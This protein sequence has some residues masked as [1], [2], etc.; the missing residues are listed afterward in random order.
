MCDLPWYRTSFQLTVAVL[1]VTQG[2]EAI[3]YMQSQ[4][5]HTVTSHGDVIISQTSLYYQSRTECSL[6]LV[7]PDSRQKVRLKFKDL[8]ITSDDSCKQ[9]FLEVRGAAKT[10][11]T[12]GGRGRVL[13]G[14]VAPRDDVT[15]SGAWLELEFKSDGAQHGRGFRVVFTAIYQGTSCTEPGMFKCANGDCISSRLRCD[16][17][18]H[19]GDGSDEAQT[20]YATCTDIYGGAA[21]STYELNLAKTVFST[22]GVLFT[23]LLLGVILWQSC[24]YIWQKCRQSKPPQREEVSLMENR[25]D[26]STLEVDTQIVD[27]DISNNDFFYSNDK[28]QISEACSREE[29]QTTEEHKIE[30]NTTN[31]TLGRFSVQK[32]H[33]SKANENTIEHDVKQK[34]RDNSQKSVSIEGGEATSGKAENEPRRVSIGRFNVQKIQDHTTSKNSNLQFPVTSFAITDP[35]KSI[36]RPKVGFVLNTGGK[37]LDR[38]MSKV[39][40]VLHNEDDTSSPNSSVAQTPSMRQG[41]ILKK[42]PK[43]PDL[44]S[45]KSK[46][47]LSFRSEPSSS[48][49]ELSSQW[50]D[51]T[52]DTDASND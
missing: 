7:A 29:E 10:H 19:C 6:K 23:G 21:I 8:D 15:S 12:H 31:M 11:A 48:D 51:T 17:V 39:K 38:R 26:D 24:A 43:Y 37:D 41:S 2:C 13:C 5:G 40:F 46:L 28:G 33:S 49:D 9:N 1:I 35:T 25:H 18:D 22:V 45:Y 50:S 47:T 30:N 16:S 27:R 3:V 20:A 4:C 32:V 14:R 52:N 44:Q 36:K 34:D 42:D